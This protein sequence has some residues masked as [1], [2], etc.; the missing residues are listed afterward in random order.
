MEKFHKKKKKTNKSGGWIK[1]T[2]RLIGVWALFFILTTSYG[3]AQNTLHHRMIPITG[4]V[5]DESGEPMSGVIVG[6]L[7]NQVSTSTGAQGD[8]KILVRNPA[9]SL[10][11]SFLGY[12]TLVIPASEAVF[13]KM[14]VQAIAIETVVV[15]GIYSRKV[16]SYTGAANTIQATD[17]QRV[18]N[19]NVFQGLK[20]LAPALYMKDNL[21]MGSNPN[22]L[23]SMSMRGVSSFP[24]ETSVSIKGNYLKDPNQPLIILDGFETTIEYVMDMDINRVESITLLKDASAKALYGSKAANGV[25]VI[26]TKRLTGNEF[27]ATYTGSVSIEMPDLT[28]Y[29]LT[30]ALEKLEVEKAEGLYNY[31]NNPEYQI[32]LEQLYCQRRELALRGLDTYWLSKPLTLGVGHKHTITVEVGDAK[33][34]R[35]M[36]TFSYNKIDG[37]MKGNDRTTISGSVTSS[38]RYKKLLFRNIMT[39]TSNHSNESPYGEFEDYVKMN[40]YWQAE[41]ADGNILRWAEYKSTGTSIPNPI[42]D[43]TIGTVNK[44]SYL[45]MLDNFYIEW[46]PL[47]GLTAMARLGISA[48]RSD[49]DEFYPATHSKFANYLEE[50]YLRRGQYFLDNGKSSDVSGDISARYIKAVGKH[51]F[52]GTLNFTVSESS[53]SAYHYEAEG[54]PNNIAADATFARQ[55]VEGTRPEGSSSLSREISALAMFSYDYD[56][57]YLADLTFREGASSLYGKDSR[58]AP[59]WSVGAGWNLHNESFLKNAEWINRLKLRGSVGVTGNQNFDTNEALGTYRYYTNWMYDNQIGAYLERL[60]NSALQWEQKTDY[61]I[62]VDVDTKWVSLVFDVFMADSKNMLT[63][64]SIPTSTGFSMVKDNLG[65]VR[66]TGFEAD[67]KLKVVQ[68]KDAF[69]TINIRA[70]HYKNYIVSLS[71]AMREAN[72]LKEQLATDRGNPVPVNLYRDGQA[73]NTIWAVP[74]VGI[75]PSNGYEVYIKKDGTLTYEYDSQ[76]LIAAGNTDPKLYGTFGF[77]GEYKGVGLS[78][79]MY[80]LWGADMYNNTLVNRVE[81]INPVYN[82]D[83]RVL[84]GRWQK[85]GQVTP[86]KKLGTYNVQEGVSTNVAY[87]E[88]TRATTRFVQK[89]NELDIASISVYYEFPARL[90]KPL[91]MQRLR[92]SSYLLNVHKFS[93]IQIER[94]LTTPFSR[95]LSFS[96]TAT[97]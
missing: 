87:Q 64:I 28:S 47:E 35:N 81:N 29:N 49:A 95:T 70:S 89:R 90:I 74:S 86:F 56:N 88:Y 5:V 96:L 75:D 85:A 92:L 45:N 76:D 2:V 18:S 25:L 84:T 58:W 71:D 48:K 61:N 82:V 13:V 8:Y 53:Y 54:F 59:S 3:F 55:Y 50:A 19:Q 42:Y 39:L 27:I 15:T 9:D 73:F 34:L 7:D 23:P 52:M 97:F 79:T 14:R 36:F 16:E 40:P 38:Y 93:S 91:R 12:Q 78:V 31:E 11:F 63:S 24:S 10:R 44:T 60:A 65:K 33:T 51:N 46:T 4:V 43:S 77:D 62:G 94:G 6:L 57:R 20:N 69:A 41:D 21:L 83:R 1:L 22:V 17:I 66:N 30:N 26:E 67:L 72:K 32:T 68:T 80:Y 37:V